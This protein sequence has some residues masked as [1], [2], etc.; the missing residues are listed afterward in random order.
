MEEL[1]VNTLPSFHDGWFEGIIISDDDKTVYLFVRT[2]DKKRSTV[3]LRGVAA[4]RIENVKKGNLIFDLAVLETS[5]VT[6]DDIEYVYE[7]SEQTKNERI[8]KLLVSTERD[9]LKLFRMRSSYGAECLAL[10]Q[11]VEL[12]EE[13]WESWLKNRI[14]VGP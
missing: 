3:L 10:C 8:P 6:A 5:Q 13:T 14:R 1:A 12:S 7:P 9:R 11:K 4:L 2:V